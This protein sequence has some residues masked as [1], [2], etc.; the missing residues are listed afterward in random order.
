M[1]WSMILHLRSIRSQKIFYYNIN[2]NTNG[3]QD[4]VIFPG[5]HLLKIIRNRKI[6]AFPGINK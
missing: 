2:G 3:Y 5:H 4:E 6:S 1:P